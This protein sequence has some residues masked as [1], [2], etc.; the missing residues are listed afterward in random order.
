MKHCI[1]FSLPLALALSSCDSSFKNE[2]SIVVVTVKES[3]DTQQLSDFLSIDGFTLIESSA[4]HEVRGFD[5][6]LFAEERMF[7]LDNS[8]DFQDIWSFDLN[9]FFLGKIGHQSE[10]VVDAYSGLNDISLTP[11]SNK[12]CALDA[13]KTSFK[14][15]DFSGNLQKNLP[16]GVFGHDMAFDG[17]NYVV[18]NEFG[19]SDISSNFYL[20]FFN[21]K[22]D[23]L[24]RLAP[25]AKDLNGNGY[26]F[27]GFMSQSS[28]SVWFSPPFC[29][30]IYEVFNSKI[31]PRYVFDFGG[32]TI[33]EAIRQRKIDGWD[34]HNFSYLTEGFIKLGRFSLI[35][36][37]SEQR[38][39][40]G[41]FDDSKGTFLS[42]SGARKDYLTEILRVGQ[43]FPKNVHSFAFVIKPDRIRYMFNKGLLDIDY[44]TKNNPSL[45]GA[46]T[47]ANTNGNTSIVLYI[48]INSEI[49][50]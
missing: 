41:L 10:T 8:T 45:L 7:V 23:L 26:T 48:S 1:L 35:E 49:D 37:F 15:Y 21:Q 13:G 3:S 47:K 39:N 5:D 44:F 29:D 4:P 17:D 50:Y 19:A 9:G 2:P 6:M 42:F 34:V 14:E 16:N 27:S 43:S 38:V 25:Y 32:Q 28:N 18:Y 20:L 12:L 40:L 33:P 36:Y 22:G 46:L 24:K 11:K 30:T 31:E